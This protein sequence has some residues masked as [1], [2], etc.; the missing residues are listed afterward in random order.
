MNGS[1]ARWK[2]RSGE[3]FTDVNLLS[4]WRPFPMRKDLFRW[5]REDWYRRRAGLPFSCR[6]RSC[7]LTIVPGSPFRRSI[8]TGT[9]GRVLSCRT[10]T[11]VT[12]Y[13]R[14][15][16]NSALRRYSLPGSTIIGGEGRGK[17]LL[18]SGNISLKICKRSFDA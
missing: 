7:F 17:F 15:V 1:G 3:E 9:E 18:T 12:T 14:T 4:A 10:K 6:I 11:A 2:K 5:E 8:I 13:I 16:R